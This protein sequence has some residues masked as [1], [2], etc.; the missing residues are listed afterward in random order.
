[1]KIDGE[2]KRKLLEELMEM[3]GHMSGEKIQAPMQD[4]EINEDDE[5]RE[6]EAGQVDPRLLELILKKKGVRPAVGSSR[7]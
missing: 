3:T 1:M 2:I 6:Q 5:N 7:G 4:A